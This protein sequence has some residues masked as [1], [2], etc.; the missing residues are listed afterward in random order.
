MKAIEMSDASESAGSTIPRRPAF[1]D[2]LFC[3]F[4]GGFVLHMIIGALLLVCAMAMGAILGIIDIHHAF[5]GLGL[6]YPLLFGLYVGFA[7]SEL[8]LLAGVVIAAIAFLIWRRV[9]VWTLIVM[10]PVCSYALYF[11][12]IEVMAPADRFKYDRWALAALGLHQLLVLV[13][14]FWCHR[15]RARAVSSF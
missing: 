14:C 4:A 1:L 8:S 3:F 15:R 13:G 10:F 12:T 5:S 9:P 6:V 7:I 2:V 11:Q